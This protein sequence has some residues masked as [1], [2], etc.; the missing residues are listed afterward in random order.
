MLLLVD[1]IKQE[2]I[3]SLKAGDSKRANALRYL[4]SLVA[5]KEMTLPAGKTLSDVEV[6]GVLQ[7]ELKNKQESVEIYKKAQRPELVAE[8]EQ[9]IVWLNK[10]LPKALTEE[11]LTEIIE[12]VKASGVVGFGPVMGQVSKQVAGRMDGAKVAEMVKKVCNL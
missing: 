3:A 9:E 12:K 10:Y 1:Q 8:I 2:A 11:E 7:K 5:K 4:L 6:V